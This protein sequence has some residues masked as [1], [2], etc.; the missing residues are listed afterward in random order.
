MNILDGAL[1]LLAKHVG[2]YGEHAAAKR[3]GFRKGDVLVEYDGSR[4][5][6]TETEIMA[7]ALNEQRPGDKTPVKVLRGGKEISLEMPVQ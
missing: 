1:A 3:A 6:R 5:S 2:E 4:A 7:R